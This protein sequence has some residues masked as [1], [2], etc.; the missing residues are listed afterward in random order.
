MIFG[1]SV[2]SISIGMIRTKVMAVL[3]GPAGFGL[4]GM[5]SSIAELAKSL[6]TMGV[7]ASGVRQVAEAVGSGEFDR[8]AR[9][10][11]VLRRISVLLGLLGAGLLILFARQISNL[12]FASGGHA[13][14]IALLAIAVFF[15]CLA[16][17]LG[18]AIQGLRR[19]SDQAK[20]PILSALSGTAIG[21][22]MVYFF[23]EQGIVP[24]LIGVAATGALASWWFM[25]KA[26]IPSPA[27]SFR[28]VGSEAGALLKLGFA[29]L[30]S[31]LMVTGAAYAVRLVLLRESG[32]EAAGL[33]QSA[34]TLGGLY[35]GLILDAM[36]S[37]FYPRLTAV[38][39]DNAVCNRMV[40]EQAEISLLLGGPGVIA[41]LTFAPL[42][43]ALFYSAKFYGAVEI[44]RWICLGMAIRIIAWPIG[45]IVLAK[46]A[47]RLFFWTELAWTLLYLVLAW[48]WVKPF[49][50]VAAGM[51]FFAS[52]V[53]HGVLLYLIVRRL[54]GFRW[55]SANQRTGLVFL[56]VIALVLCGFYLLPPL[57][58]TMAGILAVLFSSVYSLRALLR[59]VA[60]D[61][62]PQPVLRLL[63][64]LRLAPPDSGY[65]RPGLDREAPEPAMHSP[66]IEGRS[67]R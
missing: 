38:A 8:V 21:I 4:M 34:W 25:R 65:G 42:V 45:F 16:G 18:A 23:G 49:G 50:P 7:N 27:M 53:V 20:M 19:I 36:G 37:D 3:L 9:T 29:F 41:T 47:Q 28:K 12:T 1:S 62:I 66:T 33:Y 2:V 57:A 48:A 44:L 26:R 13:L 35:V 10:V 59:L 5:Y 60:L 32:V 67:M 11:T 22:P 15:G 56:A 61:R 39:T 64:R 54:S 30:A 55:V 51:A 24:S 17:G 58:G 31:A 43:I 63:S 14:D 52:H 46:G 40:N 6:A